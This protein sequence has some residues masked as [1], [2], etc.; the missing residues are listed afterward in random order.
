MILE[1]DLIRT[2]TE[3]LSFRWEPRRD[4]SESL[5]VKAVNE[6]PAYAIDRVEFS[7]LIFKNSGDI[8]SS[9]PIRFAESRKTAPGDLHG[10]GRTRQPEI[11]IPVFNLRRQP[12]V[13]QITSR[14]IDSEAPFAKLGEPA[15]SVDPNPTASRLIGFQNEIAGQSLGG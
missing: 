14:R 10:A 15:G 3:T 2:P 13:T 6:R 5:S 1:S 8:E 12:T 9:E 11:A 4:R 7:A